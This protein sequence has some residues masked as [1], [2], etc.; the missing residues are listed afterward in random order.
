M[1]N[2]FQ[3]RVPIEITPHVSFLHQ[4]SHKISLPSVKKYAEKLVAI[5]SIKVKNIYTNNWHILKPDGTS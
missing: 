5:K 3:W 2:G 1:I 4:F